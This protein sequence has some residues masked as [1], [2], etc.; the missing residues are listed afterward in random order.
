[1]HK[2]ILIS[3]LIYAGLSSSVR[4]EIVHTTLELENMNCIVC[5]YIVKEILKSIEGVQGVI[6]DSTTKTADVIFDDSNTNLNAIIKA[7]DDMGYSS[8]VRN[9]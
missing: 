8:K 3:V 1:M 4:A 6:V 2:Y 9:N 5:P 7:I